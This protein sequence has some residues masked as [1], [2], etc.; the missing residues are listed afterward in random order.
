MQTTYSTYLSARTSSNVVM[1]PV[2]PSTSTVMASVTVMTARMRKYVS[3]GGDTLSLVMR[4]GHGDRLQF[5]F[6]QSCHTAVYS[7]F[8]CTFN[9]WDDTV[10]KAIILLLVLSTCC[11]LSM[12]VLFSMMIGCSCNFTIRKW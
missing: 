7:N 12:C 11:F 2:I 10:P 9:I 5:C 6:G 8:I 3:D 4:L 1:V